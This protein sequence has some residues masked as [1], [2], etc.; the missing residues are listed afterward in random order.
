MLLLLVIAQKR[1]LAT[2][3]PGNAKA[4][5]AG[6]QQQQRCRFRSVVDD[7]LQAGRFLQ[8]EPRRSTVG[9]D[10]TSEVDR[11]RGQSAVDT[12]EGHARPAVTAR[13]SCS[14]A[15][16]YG[17]IIPKAVA[18]SITIK[19]K[20]LAVGGAGQ[21]EAGDSRTGVVDHADQRIFNTII[22]I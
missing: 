7:D 12:A 22:R 17:L 19:T 4:Q 21:V 16:S 10:A 9:S 15:V 11:S 3:Q 1:L 18:G 14:R 8:A 20:Q 5:Q 6:A 13:V 2:T